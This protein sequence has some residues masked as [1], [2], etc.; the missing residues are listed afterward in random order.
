[1]LTPSRDVLVLTT[2]IFTP[3]FYLRKM[4][5]GLWVSEFSTEMATVFFST[6]T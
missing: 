5:T 4:A 6:D 1:M 2:A 3:S